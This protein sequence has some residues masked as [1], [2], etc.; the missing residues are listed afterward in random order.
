LD[1]LKTGCLAAQ[2]AEWHGKVDAE[3][4]GLW[5]TM[6]G[7]WYNG[8]LLCPEVFGYGHAVLN[9]IMK[10]DYYNVI[11]RKILDAVNRLSTDKYGWA[12]TPTTK[13]QMLTMSRYAINNEMVIINSEH[14]VREMM[15][16][17]R[18]DRLTGASAYGRGKDDRVMAFMI[19]ICSI[20]QE[21]GDQHIT[22]IGILQP[23]DEKPKD[24]KDRLHY[25]SFWDRNKQRGKHWQDL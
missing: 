19:A 11:K 8:A 20:E 4:L 10:L 15:I 12:T 25:D 24:K 9:A 3:V 23:P 7:K 14:L 1:R 17:V 13:P 22:S 2:V 18:E 5:A 6:L 21:Y 16:F